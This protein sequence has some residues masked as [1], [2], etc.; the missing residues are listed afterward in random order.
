MKYVLTAAAALALATALP[1]TAQ[2]AAYT[3]EQIEAFAQA[4]V[5]VADIR[6]AYAADLAAVESEEEQQALV[7]EGNEAMIAAIE[8]APNITVDEYLEIG[9]AAAE[10]PELGNQVAHAVNELRDE[11]VMEG[12]GDDERMKTQAEEFTD[13]QIE[14]FAQ[15]AVD[16]ADIREA[17]PAN[18]E[19]GVFAGEIIIDLAFRTKAMIAAVEDAANITLDEYLEI[20]E[21]AAEDPELRNQVAHAVNELRDEPVMDDD[22]TE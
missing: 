18:H 6:D 7:D 8:D 11:P 15:A 9:E 4:A 21:A 3:D 22:P 10:D 1:A 13:E 12:M 19:V 17:Y 16:V 2:D 14:A 20:V 5:D